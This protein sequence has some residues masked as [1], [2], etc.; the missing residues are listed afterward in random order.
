MKPL[1]EL[2]IECVVAV[3]GYQP[4]LGG[5][6]VGRDAVFVDVD[7]W[8]LYALGGGEFQI[9]HTSMPRPVIIG[10]FGYSYV[11]SVVPPP[12]PPGGRKAKAKSLVPGDGGIVQ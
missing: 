8:E 12:L 2:H 11:E 3:P 7:G 9:K 4:I 1:R 6:A 10:G 5:P